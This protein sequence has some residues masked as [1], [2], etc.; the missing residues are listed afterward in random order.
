ME[1]NGTAISREEVLQLI[2]EAVEPKIY[3]VFTEVL[4][5]AKKVAVEAHSKAA[6]D[7][8]I[9]QLSGYKE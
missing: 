8:M 6:L 9:K 3:E 2:S 7:E 1:D 4:A 5:A